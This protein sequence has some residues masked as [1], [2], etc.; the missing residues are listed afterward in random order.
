ML[1][2]SDMD[3]GFQPVNGG[4]GGKVVSS[5]QS[6]AVPIDENT[7]VGTCWDNTGWDWLSW[8]RLW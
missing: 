8:C 6:V 4:H 1:H 2:S 7:R 3:V 5:Y